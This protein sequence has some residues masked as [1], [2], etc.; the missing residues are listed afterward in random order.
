MKGPMIAMLQVEIDS[1]LLD[2]STPDRTL[3]LRALVLEAAR[4]PSSRVVAV[5]PVDYA[6]LLM[7]TAEELAEVDGRRDVFVR[8]PASYRKPR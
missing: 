2:V 4:H 3:A 8:P 1:D 7:E 5:I 6:R